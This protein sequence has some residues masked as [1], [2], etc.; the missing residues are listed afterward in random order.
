MDVLVMAGCGG[1]LVA[2]A[3]SNETGI[4]VTRLL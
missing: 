4:E 2:A 3:T 1:G